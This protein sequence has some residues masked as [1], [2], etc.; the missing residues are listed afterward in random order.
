M[1]RQDD[2]DVSVFLFE[3][4]FLTEVNFLDS[5]EQLIETYYNDSRCKWQKCS[6]TEYDL[7]F[8]KKSKNPTA[9][10]IWKKI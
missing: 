10:K 3:K 4:E 8:E 2:I 7:Y 9:K 6:W 5:M 1:E